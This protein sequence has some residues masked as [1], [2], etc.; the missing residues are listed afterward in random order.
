MASPRARPGPPSS[1]LRASLSFRY[2]L[3]IISLPPLLIRPTVA[4]ESARRLLM[5]RARPSGPV[6]RSTIKMSRGA[7]DFAAKSREP[8]CR[9]RVTASSERFRD[10]ERPRRSPSLRGRTNRGMCT[11]PRPVNDS[12]GPLTALPRDARRTLALCARFTLPGPDRCCH[13]ERDGQSDP[14]IEWADRW[15]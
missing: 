14:A 6:I 8:P 15:R 10:N 13:L 3:S 11:L 1:F 5:T 7:S 2:F 9:S 12:R 4:A